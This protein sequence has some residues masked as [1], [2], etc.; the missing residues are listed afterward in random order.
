MRLSVL[1]AFAAAALVIPTRPALETLVVQP[2]SRIWVEGTS[3]LKAFACKA[4]EF[5]M[6]VKAEGAGAVPAV[7]AGQKAVRTVELTVPS[8]KMDCANGTMN[9]HM[10]KA[11]KA[12]D[13]ATIKFT[14]SGYD[15]AANAKGAAGTMRGA[16]NLGGAEHPVNV[17]AVATDAG[18]GAL[19][20][21]GS[22]ELALSSFD[23]KAPTLMF[24]SI[25]VG[26]KV[27][28][29]FDIVLKN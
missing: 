1:H 26:D 22:Y 7:L 28:V 2:E 4:P 14:L 19:R 10:R 6:T 23:L 18:N 29:K 25:K 27:Q 13:N 20:V 16:L 15:V 9:E 21:V 11:I 24:G 3:S 8:A 17:S 5:T 12:D